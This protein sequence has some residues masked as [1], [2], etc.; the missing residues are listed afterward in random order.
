[1]VIEEVRPIFAP[2]LTFFDPILSFATTGAIENLREN[3][4]TVGKCLY[5]GSL[6]PES[7]KTKNLKATYRH[8]QTSCP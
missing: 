5:L 8:V 7:D 3:A 1:M 4:P 6:S 2:P